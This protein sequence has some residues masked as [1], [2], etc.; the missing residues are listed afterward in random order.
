MIETGDNMDRTNKKD[1][2]DLVAE[3]IGSTKKDVEIVVDAL[4]DGIK[5]ILQRGDEVNICNFGVFYQCNRKQRIGTH[6]KE[7]TRIVIPESKRISF[8]A[9]KSFKINE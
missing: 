2:I 3:K 6:P 4:F 8:R 7:H 9:S 1:L 5:D